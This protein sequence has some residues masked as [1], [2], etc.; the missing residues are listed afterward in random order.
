[1]IDADLQKRLHRIFAEAH[2]LSQNMH[3]P[4][5]VQNLQRH[6]AEAEEVMQEHGNRL[7]LKPNYGVGTCL[8][9]LLRHCAQQRR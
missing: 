5:A 6:L 8:S 4:D 9:S 1:M 3:M 2:N 7:R